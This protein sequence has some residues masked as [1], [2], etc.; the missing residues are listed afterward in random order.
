MLLLRHTFLNFHLYLLYSTL[1]NT[2]NN[3]TRLPTT[4]ENH[5]QEEDDKEDEEEAAT[6][7]A[8]AATGEGNNCVGSICILLFLVCQGRKRN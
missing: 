2:F 1:F 8:I 5:R 7:T 6:V 4:K 3:N